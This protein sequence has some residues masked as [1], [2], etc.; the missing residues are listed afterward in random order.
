MNS[1]FDPKCY[2]LAEYFIPEASEEDKN[3]LA[4]LIQATIEDYVCI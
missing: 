2:E 1:T 4:R 3:E